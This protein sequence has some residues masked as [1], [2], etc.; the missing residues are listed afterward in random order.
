MSRLIV[1]ADD[2]R[3]CVEIV[4]DNEGNARGVCQATMHT[5]RTEPDRNYS[6]EDAIEMAKS[7]VDHQHSAR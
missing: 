5:W 4:V 3:I 1:A 7:H 6:L 2:M